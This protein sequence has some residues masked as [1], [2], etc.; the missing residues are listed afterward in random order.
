MNFAEEEKNSGVLE[1]AEGPGYESAFAAEGLV[2]SGE[3]INEVE[4]VLT[5]RA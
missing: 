2:R 3:S 4:F 5:V 1:L